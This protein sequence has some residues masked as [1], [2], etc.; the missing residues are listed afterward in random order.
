M[1]PDPQFRTH[2]AATIAAGLISRHGIDHGGLAPD[3]IAEKALAI[4][5]AIVG[6]A[7]DRPVETDLG[8]YGQTVQTQEGQERLHAVGSAGRQEEN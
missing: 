1:R 6:K 7:D 8:A 4:A 2:I 3:Q 5:D